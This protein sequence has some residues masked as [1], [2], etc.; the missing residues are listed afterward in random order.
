MQ[1]PTR[2]LDTTIRFVG[3]YCSS[4]FS[5]SLH[6]TFSS[7][8]KPSKN[9]SSRA[10]DF[11]HKFHLPPFHSPHLPHW[12]RLMSIC[13]TH[14]YRGSY[15]PWPRKDLSTACYYLEWDAH[16]RVRVS[17]KCWL[18]L[19]ST[20]ICKQPLLNGLK[21]SSKLASTQVQEM[22]KSARNKLCRTEGHWQIC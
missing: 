10:N 11:C 8:S 6:C 7:P 2:F 19:C 18:T 1:S 22:P 9:V 21:L 4:S 16:R 14:V 20:D 17:S 13:Q 12:L 3:S 5:L 15:C